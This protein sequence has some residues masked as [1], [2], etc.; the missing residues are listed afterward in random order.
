MSKPHIKTIAQALILLVTVSLLSVCKSS[1]ISDIFNRCEPDCSEINSELFI[2]EIENNF[3]EGIE[4]IEGLDQGT[5]T[6]RWVLFAATRYGTDDGS[7]RTAND[8]VFTKTMVFTDN[9]DEITI[10]DCEQEEAYTLTESGFNIPKDSIFFSSL[11]FEN[12]SGVTLS[13]NG[14]LRLRGEWTFT[15]PQN[16]Q[17]SI[18]FNA[19]KISDTSSATSAIGSVNNTDDIFCYS[20]LDFFTVIEVFVNNNWFSG[21]NR[22]VEEL[23]MKVDPVSASEDKNIYL[24]SQSENGFETSSTLRFDQG[25]DD[26]YECPGVTSFG[27]QTNDYL[28]YAG[29][30]DITFNDIDCNI[31]GRSTSSNDFSFSLL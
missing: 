19:Y 24:V 27:S 20:Y 6:G 9:S 14:A 25:F 16:T 10:S 1:S 17:E 11:F 18:T 8:L 13:R 28:S 29:I 21:G 30:F 12:K 26:E 3:V 7:T 5:L 15:T 4:T 22:R 23:V 2:S 31:G